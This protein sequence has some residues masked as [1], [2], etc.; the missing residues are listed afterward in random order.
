MCPVKFVLPKETI[1]RC[2]NPNCIH[3]KIVSAKIIRP[4]NPHRQC[5]CRFD[6][7]FCTTG[8]MKNAFRFTKTLGKRHYKYHSGHMR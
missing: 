3:A 5:T 8:C 7:W 4:A 6:A 1:K 2:D